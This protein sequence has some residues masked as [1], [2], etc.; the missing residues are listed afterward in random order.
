MYVDAAY[1][2]RRTS[3]VCR[4]VCLSV[5]HCSE[6]CKNGCTDRDTFWDVDSSGPKE[7]SIRWGSIPTQRCNF[8]GKWRPIVKYRDPCRERCKKCCTEMHLGCWSSLVGSGNHVLDLSVHW[9]TLVRWTRLNRPCMAATR[10]DVNLLWPL[11]VALCNTADHYIFA[12]SFVLSSSFFL[13]SPNLS[14]RRLDVCHT[15]THGVTLVRI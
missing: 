13:S 5:S 6:P 3:V 15:S 7:P 8:E 1:C 2:Y 11:M 4:S 14:R 9:H 10:P 12:L